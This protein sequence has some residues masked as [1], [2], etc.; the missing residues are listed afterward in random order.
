MCCK[1]LRTWTNIDRLLY[2]NEPWTVSCHSEFGHCNP[3][4][5]ETLNQVFPLPFT[6]FQAAWSTGACVLGAV[7]ETEFGADVYRE[8]ASELGLYCDHLLDDK[9]DGRLCVICQ[10]V[11]CVFVFVSH[12]FL[13]Q[14]VV[15]EW[16]RE[17]MQT[18]RIPQTSSNQSWAE[19]TTSPRALSGQT[20]RHPLLFFVDTQSSVWM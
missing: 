3:K 9:W 11:Q 14:H 7:L 16:C 17:E 18:G 15:P 8:G 12:K 1:A 13:L 19:L 5:L 2:R 10:D 20:H 4:W 6:V